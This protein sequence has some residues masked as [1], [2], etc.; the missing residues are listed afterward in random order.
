MDGLDPGLDQPITLDVADLDPHATWR[1]ANAEVRFE[2]DVNS[3]LVAL[4]WPATSAVYARSI[5][6]TPNSMVG[7]DL[8]PLVNRYY[9][10]YQETILGSEGLIVSKRLAAPFRNAEER[11]VLWSLECQAEGD[12]VLR[13]DV[14]IVWGEPLSQRIVDGLLVAQ[15]NPRAGQGV[16][17]QSN[18]EST[19]IF[20]NPHGP[21]ES[22]AL[23]DEAGTA[24]L[25]YYVLVNG[26]VDVS[27]VLTVSDVGEQVAWSAFLALREGER[28]LEGSRR[29]W[30]ETLKTARIW[31]PD[32]RF[33]RAVHAGKRQTLHHLVH[34]RT[35]LAASDR[36]VLRV[37]ALVDGLDVLD[38]AL[39]RNLLAHL[40]RTAERAQG[41]LPL[42]LKT[43][44]RDAP[45]DP[46]RAVAHTNGA[47]LVALHRHLAR[48]WDADVLGSHYEAASLCSEALIAAPRDALQ[49]AT[50]EELLAL[51]VALRAA[52]KL[53]TMRRD[54]VNTV[55]WENEACEFER[56]AESAG[57]ARAV[58]PPPDWAQLAGW[59]LSSDRP[60]HFADPWAG[61]RL[62]SQAVWQGAGV[63]LEA[64]G[65][66]LRP[67]FPAA[68]RWWALM[69]LP[70]P[71]GLLSLVWDGER[72]HS[73]LPLRTPL[74]TVVQDRIR[75]LRTDELDFDLT[76]EFGDGDTERSRFHPRFPTQT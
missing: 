62:A 18:A 69:G 6:I 74:P 47:Y 40:R 57:A 10:G 61:I 63:T 64:G 22:A 42:Q 8:V 31:S 73:T 51:G 12:Y 15:R 67:A 75:A 52:Q 65:L 28:T 70:T 59:R 49:R 4:E 58:E 56:A 48:H 3:D 44:A 1:I 41:R 24:R 29:A 72:L 68:W 26:I 33:N 37:P 35:G 55:R 76:F 54:G 36:S 20:G 32:V 45:S 2:A 53:A 7:D 25:V 27:F 21:P 71:H 39:S 60:W 17:Q 30:E 66:A 16:Y 11:A 46:G 19:R 23:D 50:A 5:R 9:P 14:A 34:L 43:R 38:V 13:L